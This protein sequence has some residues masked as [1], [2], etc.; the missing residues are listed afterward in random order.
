MTDTLPT[1]AARVS[2]AAEFRAQL[3]AFSGDMGV[4]D[5]F[6]AP[7]EAIV[8]YR[9]EK[10]FAE[11]A[12]D[13]GV[14]FVAGSSLSSS[15]F[16]IDNAEVEL[17]LEHVHETCVD[18]IA[19][20]EEEVDA[21]LLGVWR[22]PEWEGQALV[23]LLALGDWASDLDCDLLEDA[24]VEG[25]QILFSG[26]DNSPY[27]LFEDMELGLE[28]QARPAFADVVVERLRD[29]VVKHWETRASARAV[30]GPR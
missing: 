14:A 18:A 27:D 20:G 10:E 30:F 11:C 19:E 26:N 2:G 16:L 8:L 1:A 29:Q 5:G 15:F 9:D 21:A 24:D 4:C 7:D 3:L 13:P 28:A 12:I 17:F 6:R 25:Q 23:G 22:V